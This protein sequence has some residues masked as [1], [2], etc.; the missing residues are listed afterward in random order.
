MSTGGRESRKGAAIATNVTLD[1]TG[2]E[3]CRNR[4]LKETE[5]VETNLP[6]NYKV[7]S[8]EQST[9]ILLLLPC[10]PPYNFGAFRI[11]INFP[12]EFPFAP[13][14]VQ[15]LTK[16]FHPSVDESGT[17][18]MLCLKSGNWMPAMRMNQVLM[19]VANLI[20]NMEY[21]QPL[22]LDLV[23]LLNRDESTF[24]RKAAEFTK[25]F[26]EKRS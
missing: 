24:Y 8:T 16:I 15:F 23:E 1:A 7:V 17:L 21:D 19:K 10:K 4:I 22:R 3:L 20:E 5:K 13:P 6:T 18:G 9:W 14:K 25:S 12:A 11:K 26:A 2:R